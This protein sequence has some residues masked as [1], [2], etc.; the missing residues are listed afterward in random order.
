ML[1]QQ[2]EVL[3]AEIPSPLSYAER[4]TEERR[5]GGEI[6]RERERSWKELLHVERK[7]NVQS[8][9]LFYFLFFICGSVFD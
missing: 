5:R 6:E 1:A 8:N 7:E 4:R 9:S 3:I 2:K